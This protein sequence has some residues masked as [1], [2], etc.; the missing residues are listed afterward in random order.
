MSVMGSS[1]RQKSFSRLA[2]AER[3]FEVAAVYQQR[4]AGNSAQSS[5]SRANIENDTVEVKKSEQLHTDR[6]H[7]DSPSDALAAKASADRQI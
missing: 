6:N 2:R 3:P 5:Q 4:L 7:S 1:R